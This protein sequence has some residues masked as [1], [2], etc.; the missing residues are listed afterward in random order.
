MRNTIS[1]NKLFVDLFKGIQEK[2]HGVAQNK[3]WWDGGDRNDGELIAL[4]HSE[5]SEA[6][7]TLRGS[8]PASSDKLDGYLGVEEEFADVIIRIMDMSEKRGWR[9]GEAVLAKIKYNEDRSYRHGG[10]SF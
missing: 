6:L 10:K 7:E 4:I 2:V 9:V 3:G 1:T 5:L 8:Q